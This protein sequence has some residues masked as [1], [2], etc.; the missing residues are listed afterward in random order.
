MKGNGSMNPSSN[1]QDNAD[2]KDQLFNDTDPAKAAGLLKKN[3]KITYKKKPLVVYAPLIIYLMALAVF[4]MILAE[5][6]AFDSI[7]GQNEAPVVHKI[8]TYEYVKAEKENY[9]EVYREDGAM[10]YRIP[11]GRI[12]TTA[13]SAYFGRD[14]SE[15]TYD[16]LSTIRFMY[17]DAPDGDSNVITA[18]IGADD[19]LGY[20]NPYDP[21]G[22]DFINSMEH[23]S[24]LKIK[25]EEIYSDSYSVIVKDLETLPNLSFFGCNM[26]ELDSGVPMPLKLTGLYVKKASLNTVDANLSWMKNLIYFR[27]GESFDFNNNEWLGKR[28]PSLRYLYLT[29]LSSTDVK[30]ISKCFDE[31]RAL[32][33]MFLGKPE[34]TS[35]FKNMKKL[36][37]LDI[38]SI[39]EFEFPEFF[40][41][42]PDI[43]CLY[44]RNIDFQSLEGISSLTSLK[45]LGIEFSKKLP[46]GTAANLL[47]V[48]L[49]ESIRRLYLH[50]VD[51]LS[52]LGRM[53]TL[54]D[55]K[56]YNCT[57]KELDGQIRNERWLKLLSL[58][59]MKIDS[60]EL[61]EAIALN[62]SLYNVTFN[63]CDITEDMSAFLSKS[64]ASTLSFINT[65]LFVTKSDLKE[66][67]EI[68]NINAINCDFRLRTVNPD[69]TSTIAA[70][71][72]RAIYDYFPDIKVF[73]VIN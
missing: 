21:F 44:M 52:V 70:S 15:I 45:L 1:N 38:G 13:L 3:V 37:Y 17:F 53:K 22:M 62:E 66:N 39:S 31:L 58:N 56:L 7:E 41:L 42:I 61:L 63:R 9:E 47:N 20:L 36:E 27:A 34:S 26:S 30:Y 32:N 6:G 54:N 48:Q 18:Y 8:K 65:I 4:I 69:Q 11:S 14:I 60:S 5:N 46:E 50:N 16:D 71:N 59:D 72:I 73:N 12:M 19:Y 43:K 51:D 49:P 33:V 10:T 57:T 55:I 68:Q 35:F 64:K 2:N 28:F 40:S 23:K 67:A 29:N 25:P 24:I